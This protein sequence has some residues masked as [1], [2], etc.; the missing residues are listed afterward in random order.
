MRCLHEINVK[1]NVLPTDEM[2]H[3]FEP[4]SVAV[5]G[6]SRDPKK[7]G[8]VIISNLQK[9][10]YRGRLFPINPHTDE[11]LGIKSLPS[12]GAIQ[13][14]VDVAV[15][16]V[17]AAVV[18]QVMGDCAQNGTRSVVIIS[19]GFDEAGEGGQRR[20]EETLRI[21][22]QGGIRILGPNTTGI[23]SPRS[24]FTTTFV[25]LN[26]KTKVGPVAFIAQTGM[27]AGVILHHIVTAQHFGISR[28]AGVGNK[29]DI[30]E[31]DILDYL[32]EDEDTR[33]VMMYLE[34]LKDGRRFFEAA[35][36]FTRTKPLVLLKGGR[37]LAGA[38]AAL[39]HTGSIA[40]NHNLMEA[41]F[42][43]AGIIPARDTE[44]M[45]DFAK[46]LAY[47]PLPRGPRVGIGS[48]SGGA[49]V[50]A[51]DAV[52]EAGLVL[53]PIGLEALSHV[54]ELLPEWAMA[55]HPLDLEPLMEVVGRNEGYRIGLETLL[56]DSTVDMCL[57]FIGA[58]TFQKEKGDL[59]AT[60]GPLLL[61]RDK[62][63][64]VS[65]I[66]SKQQSEILAA[67][68]EEMK[69]PAYPTVNRAAKSF[70]A[71]FQYARLKLG[72]SD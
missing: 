62:P 49:A 70:A 36:R 38:K 18:P 52:I 32:Y 60:L 54:Q 12:V 27:F 43:Q 71:L 16:A 72:N 61:K 26:E 67:E 56:R 9:L 58:G 66:G 69:V 48:I 65:L 3:F 53:A 29:S 21:A 2:R 14:K 1:E 46:M 4:E 63:V 34:G 17:P 28:V 15:I 45:I 6:A 22:R 19:S 40:G 13:E 37:T 59:I 47:Q 7:F 23:F 42:K 25:P 10:G 41:L 55:A 31:T 24:R 20:L 33:A 11:I 39:S 64:V 8:S 68:F 50:M 57:L 44:E 51:G 35:R 5:V 30:D